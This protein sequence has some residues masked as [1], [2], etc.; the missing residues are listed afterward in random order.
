M[1]F[2]DFEK[3][4]ESVSRRKVIN[5]VER[6]QISLRNM[7]LQRSRYAVKVNGNTSTEFQIKI[8]L[9][10][11]NPLSTKLFN[12]VLGDTIRDRGIKA[13]GSIFTKSQHCVAYVDDVLMTRRCQ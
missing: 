8:D 5:T 13:K 9:R 1:L 6:L 3:A 10:Q 7:T 2:V 4:N 12:V 11:G